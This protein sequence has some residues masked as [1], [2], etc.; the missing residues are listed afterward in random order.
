MRRAS[1]RELH[2]NT[3]GLVNDVVQGEVVLIE[4]RGVPVA[5]LRPISSAFSGKVL[6]N[7]AKLLAKFPKVRGDSGRFLEEDRS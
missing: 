6:P 4:R 7:R 5:E 1:V 3:S 2:L